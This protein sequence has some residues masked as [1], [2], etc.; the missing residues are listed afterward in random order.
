MPGNGPTP[1]TSSQPL[2]H[3]T[4]AGCIASS[5]LRKERTAFTKQQIQQLEKDFVA[6]NYLTRLRRYEIAVALD[7]TERQ[8]PRPLRHRASSA[9]GSGERGLPRKGEGSHRKNFVGHMFKYTIFDISHDTSLLL[10]HPFND[11]FQDNPGKPAQK[12][13]PF[14]ILMKQE[15]IG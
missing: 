8:V 5:R 12:G 14:W 4:G 6:H 15:M 3:V 9:W 13:K 7:L 10:L 1:M 11:F 2:E